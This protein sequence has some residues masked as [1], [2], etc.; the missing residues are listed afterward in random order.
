MG[1]SLTTVFKKV[2]V[3]GYLLGLW[4]R[5][6]EERLGENGIHCQ[7]FLV[8]K[9]LKKWILATGI[10]F[11]KNSRRNAIIFQ[12]CTVTKI[13]ISLNFLH[14][15]LYLFFN[16]VTLERVGYIYIYI[17]LEQFSLLYFCEISQKFF[18]KQSVENFWKRA[19]FIEINL[20]TTRLSSMAKRKN[21]GSSWHFWF[22]F[23]TSFHL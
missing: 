5:K 14:C 19:S 8:S 18:R 10:L 6:N 3:T 12:N 17:Y 23:V 2:V 9:S 22:Y 1:N 4:W 20:W 21:M 16:K 11:Q 7:H 15:H 13:Y